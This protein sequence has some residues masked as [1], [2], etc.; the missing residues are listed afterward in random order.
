MD[1]MNLEK[2]LLGSD[3]AEFLRVG[4][5]VESLIKTLKNIMIYPQDNP[6]PQEQKKR[7]FEKFS[8]F[9]DDYGELKLEVRYSQISYK[10]EMIHQDY[11]QKEG[12]AY[13]MHRDGI[14]EITFKAGLNLRE[15]S[16]L[17]EV[18]KRGLTLSTMEDDLV[19]LLWEHDFEHIS[20]KVVDEFLGE[21]P[22]I[23]LLDK[24]V[25][26]SNQPDNLSSVYRSEID[27]PEEKG[28]EG[29]EEEQAVVQK[30]LQNVKRFV[31]EEVIKIDHLLEKDEG[32]DGMGNV[33]SIMEEILSP[34][35]ELP[36][37]K[38]TTTLMETTLNRLLEDGDFESSFRVVKLFR[39][40]ERGYRETSPQRSSR[41]VQ[42]I[43]RAGDSVRIKLVGAALDRDEKLDLKW[44]KAYLSSL[45]WNSIL[46]ILNMLGE[47]KN[48]PARRM[49]SDVLAFFGK[50]HLQMV[51]RGISNHRWYVVRNVV[52]VLGKI[53]DT[54]AIPYLRET[55]KHDE[56]RVR[57]ETVR[58]LELIGGFEALKVLLLALDDSSSRIRIKAFSLLGKAG[59]KIA[60]EPILRMAKSKDFKEKSEEEKKAILFSLAEIGK[61]QAVG[62]LKKIAK[63]RSWFARGRDQQTKILAV[64]ALGIINTTQ[65]RDLLEELSRKAKKEL[66][67]IS[68]NT[69]ERLDRQ[70]AKEAQHHD[71]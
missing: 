52:G 5:I 3:E 4:K 54:K 23:P 68:K 45:H 8:E 16:D 53:G 40:L 30:S 18:F 26:D 34:Q 31:E 35:T 51:A 48:Y 11:K 7:F 70:M 60:F 65:A 37:F 21:E 41:L 13:S 57:R 71:N 22:E 43:N 6:I 19:T 59:Q 20:Y 9:L 61:D 25:S 29:N 62:V 44:A 56:F 46:N 36:E 42:A 39:E 63:K 69:L 33:L 47:L 10:G 32:Y 66:R 28:T 58:S 55:I 64:K 14:S 50:D 1:R 24:S 49:V 15:L 12:L 2:G 17:L 38:E 67:Q 27:L